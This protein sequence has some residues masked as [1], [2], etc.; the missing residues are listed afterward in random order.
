MEKPIT[1]TRV[2]LT[3]S[4]GQSMPMQKGFVMA[5]APDGKRFVGRINL[6]Q[7]EMGQVL[8]EEGLK[9]AEMIAI[10][11]DGSNIQ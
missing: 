6:T 3:F 10:P 1:V 2:D 11:I 4:N 7:E 9:Y 8:L 5:I